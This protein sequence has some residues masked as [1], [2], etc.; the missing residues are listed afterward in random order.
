MT[1]GS[2]KA[3]SVSRRS[4]KLSCFDKIRRVD[5]ISLG[6]WTDG[7]RLCFLERTC[8]WEMGRKSSF[9]NLGVRVYVPYDKYDLYD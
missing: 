5:H 1:D 2:R 6:I 9:E 8:Y 3:L 7:V 4:Q